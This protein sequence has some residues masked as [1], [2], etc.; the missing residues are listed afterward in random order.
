MKSTD[1]KRWFKQQ[2]GIPV[3]VEL[4]S[5]VYI[6]PK[7]TE[8]PRDPLEYEHQFPLE[9]GQKCLALQYPGEPKMHTYW[10]GNIHSNQ[11]VMNPNQWQLIMQMYA[12][13]DMAILASLDADAKGGDIDDI[14]AA[15]RII[16]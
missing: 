16:D 1:L 2:F 8:N 3:R 5:R 14:R 13:E 15:D 11:I 6:L 7:K 10:S 4:N 12:D 9:L